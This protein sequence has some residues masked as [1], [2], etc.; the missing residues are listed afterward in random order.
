MKFVSTLLKILSFPLILAGG[1][2]VWYGVRNWTAGTADVVVDGK[3]LLASRPAAA[4]FRDTVRYD[5]SGGSLRQDNI[6][7]I[8][9]PARAVFTA[10][11]GSDT[12]LSRL[13]VISSDPKFLGPV[14]KSFQKV[15]S[16]AGEI[17]VRSSEPTSAGN[18]QAQFDALVQILVAKLGDDLKDTARG[19]AWI[20]GVAVRCTDTSMVG[21]GGVAPEYWE[22]RTEGVPSSSAVYGS[23]A[24]G[25]AAI[26]LGFGV[27]NLLARRERREREA[28]EEERQNEQPLV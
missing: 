8:K 27:Q 13:V 3:A 1:V 18:L 7:G 11:T 21:I 23:I 6:V 12:G 16:V 19:R 28:E 4:L 2:G 15:D 25:V 17:K 10:W 5:L 24:G 20:Q 26:V 9:S 14:V 22:I